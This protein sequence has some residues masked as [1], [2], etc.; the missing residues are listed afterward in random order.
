MHEAELDLAEALAAEVGR[1]VGGPQAA[2]LDL[3][4]QRLDRALEALLAELLED[5]LDR[6]DLLA[7]ELAHPVELLLELGLRREVPRHPHTA[8][9]GSLPHKGGRNGPQLPHR[10][11][12][13][14]SMKPL[15]A[16]LALLALAAGAAPAAAEQR[17]ATE[18]APLH[19]R[20]LRRRD[21]V[22]LL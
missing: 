1:Q 7:H 3:L 17:L 14:R 5:R 15:A 21:R 10:A 13:D 2:L 4:L 11:A 22:E 9:S 12:V 8:S 16:L 18:S 6:P 19:R 20:R